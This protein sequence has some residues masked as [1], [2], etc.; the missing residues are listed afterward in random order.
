MMSRR[1]LIDAGVFR[2]GGTGGDV[3]VQDGEVLSSEGCGK[4]W[5]LVAWWI[6]K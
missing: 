3:L 4:V 6:F 1:V 2:R 5:L